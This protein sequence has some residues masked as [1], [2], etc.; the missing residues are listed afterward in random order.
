M[1]SFFIASCGRSTLKNH[2]A[3][4]ASIHATRLNAASKQLLAL[5]GRRN[6]HT[7]AA[8]KPHRIADRYKQSPMQPPRRLHVV[9]DLGR[10]STAE[11]P[12]R[13]EIASQDQ[14]KQPGSARAENRKFAGTRIPSGPPCV[15]PLQLVKRCVAIRYKPRVIPRCTSYNR[16]TQTGQKG[17]DGWR[18]LPPATGLAGDRGQPFAAVVV[19]EAALLH[20]RH[21]RRT[22]G[23]VIVTAR[24]AWQAGCRGCR[25]GTIVVHTAP[26]LA[27]RSAA[28]VVSRRGRGQFS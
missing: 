18:A 19:A 28:E 15:V 23:A 13:L 26:A 10:R 3:A 22:L 11:R 12:A 7:F 1:A 4:K 24:A 8:K 9:F 2:P 6:P 17:G 25:L 27:A 16:R 14:S 20:T 21:L 5:P